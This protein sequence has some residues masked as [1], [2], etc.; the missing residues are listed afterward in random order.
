MKCKVVTLAEPAGAS[1]DAEP[2]GLWDTRQLLAR[3]PISRRTLHARIKDGKI[4]AIKL[5]KR[6]LFHPPSVEAA[7]LRLQRGA[8]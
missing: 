6:L 4:P 2:A 5:G 8:A 3:V 1:T 7:L